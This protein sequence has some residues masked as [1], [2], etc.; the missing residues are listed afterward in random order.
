MAWPSGPRVSLDFDGAMLSGSR[1]LLPWLTV[2]CRG[3]RRAVRLV[4]GSLR[5]QAGVSCDLTV[6]PLTVDLSDDAMQL[7]GDSSY[8]RDV[9]DFE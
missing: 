5:D 8:S 2:Y 7:S 1:L 9:T 4:V 3:F 6:A